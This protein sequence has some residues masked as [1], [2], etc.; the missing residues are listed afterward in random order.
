MNFR[1]RTI[2]LGVI[3]LAAAAILVW[4]T[5]IT[6]SAQLNIFSAAQPAQESS[7]TPS[8][9]E[10]PTPTPTPIALSSVVQASENIESRIEEIKR[11]VLT[12]T[13]VLDVKK[14]LESQMAETASEEKKAKRDLSGLPALEEIATI[15]EKW[16]TYRSSVSLWQINLKQYAEK[17][18]ETDKE[19]ALELKNWNDLKESISRLVDQNPKASPTPETNAGQSPEG[20]TS[21]QNGGEQSPPPSPTP[22]EPQLTVK[23]VPVAIRAKIDQTISDIKKAQTSIADARTEILEVQPLLSKEEKRV[24]SILDLAKQERNAA[25]S[26]LISRDSPP[27]W[28]YKSAVELSGGDLSQTIG[29]QFGET[30]QYLSGKIGA[31]IVLVLIGLFIFLGLLG[32]RRRTR[33]LVDKEPELARAL[34]FFEMPLVTGILFTIA[35]SGIFLTKAPDMLGALLTVAMLAPGYVILRR[36]IDKPLVPILNVLVLFYVFDEILRLLT[37]YPLIYRLLFS[38]EMLT[39]IVL[40]VWIYRQRAAD[41]SFIAEHRRLVELLKKILL[42]S[43]I[44]FGISFVAN[45]FGFVSLARLVARGLLDS[46]YAGLFLYAFYLVLVSLAEYA[47][48]VRPLSRLKMMSQHRALVVSKVAKAIRWL[49]VFTWFLLALDYLYLLEPF[50]K[51]LGTV[52]TFDLTLGSFSI[53]LLEI[54]IFLFVVWL[55]FALSRLIRFVLEEDVYTRVTLKEG[56]PYAVSTILHYALLVGGFTLAILSLGIDL[57]KFTILAGAFGVGLGFGLQNIVQNFVSGIILLFERPVTIGDVIQK[58]NDIGSLKSIGL[59]A[60]IIGTPEGAEIIVPNGVLI[61]EEV[62]NWTP[63]EHNR[64]LDVNVGVAYG[65]DVDQ[66]IELLMEVGRSHPEVVT[67]PGPLVLFSGFGDSSIDF[68][69]RTW[70]NSESNWWVIRS[71]LTIGVYKALTEANIEIPFPQRD[72]NLRS[73][74]ADVP[75]EVRKALRERDPEADNKK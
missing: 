48:R 35:I 75:A 64:R 47:V 23:E 58:G 24:R 19:L 36:V 18:N 44:P 1:S 12:Q 27:L 59:R 42:V 3:A 9:S 39:A 26:N 57:T 31:I 51:G 28:S 63:A 11:T 67:D 43:A 53:T 6:V 34:I 25:L 73:V 54:L 55:A 66:V 65:S 38:I 17:L 61:S 56:V 45:L 7:P 20:Q 71:D 70:A 49:F 13:T 4:S 5:A 21:E 22:A 72:L 29:G 15:T 10:T 46:A 37:A 40:V 33:A 32:A 8:P 69:L 68:Q 30:G 16:N 62:T 52:L 2:N 14:A 74:S 60:S 41:V 50:G